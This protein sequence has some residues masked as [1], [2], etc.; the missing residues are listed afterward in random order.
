MNTFSLI[1][2]LFAAISLIACSGG[3]S[4]IQGSKAAIRSTDTLPDFDV[5]GLKI[6]MTQAD[7]NQIT[8]QNG[9]APKNSRDLK[10]NIYPDLSWEQLV[11][12]E[13][14]EWVSKL[15]RNSH[16]GIGTMYFHKENREFL[17][18]TFTAFKGG[19]RVTTV[20]YSL[21]DT[22]ITPTQFQEMI[23]EK[24]KTLSGSNIG[25]DATW[26]GEQNFT[27]NGIP[28]K[29]TLR[30][31]SMGNNN[32]GLAQNTLGLQGKVDLRAYKAAIKAEIPK[33]EAK[34]TF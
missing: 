29:E 8:A 28:V 2:S 33:S 7:V 9:Y 21:K 20:N 23:S 27:I 19:P 6:G 25:A 5:S 11:K 18:V 32:S 15:N 30:K 13:K 3:K 16:D 31:L 26:R 17:N 24:Y 4:D 22:T 1:L 14:G 12:I 34:T 10:G